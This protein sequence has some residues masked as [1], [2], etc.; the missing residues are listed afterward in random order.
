ML[1]KFSEGVANKPEL[2]DEVCDLM[3]NSIKAK[4]SLIKEMDKNL[5]DSSIE[6]DEDNALV[7][8]LKGVLKLIKTNVI[9]KNLIETM[10]TKI[11][12]IFQKVNNII[13]NVVEPKTLNIAMKEQER[14][15]L[16]KSSIIS[17]VGYLLNNL[18]G[19]N[20][21]LSLNNLVNIFTFD[22]DIISLYEFYN[23]Y[24]HFEFNLTDKDNSSLGNFDVA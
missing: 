4:L 14:I 13:L 16:K 20:G 17:V 15:D 5:D 2:G 18:T 21:P 9:E 6:E 3:I 22:T 7:P 24:I 11:G 23:K 8:L 19:A 10:N 1:L 12:R